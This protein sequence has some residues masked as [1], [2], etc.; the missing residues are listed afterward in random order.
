MRVGDATAENFGWPCYEGPG[1]QAGYDNLNNPVCESPL[2]RGHGPGVTAP[3]FSYHHNTPMTAGGACPDSDAGAL[4]GIT[5]YPG[6]PFPDEYDGALFFADFTRHC[7]MVMMAGA[8]GRPDPA[9]LRSSAWCSRPAAP[10]GPWP[11]DLEVGPDGVLY[12]VDVYYGCCT[13]SATPAAGPPTAADG[14]RDRH[15]GR[16]SGR[17]DRALRRLRLPRPGGRRAD[18]R[19]GPRRRRRVRRRHRR[20]RDRAPTP[21]R[22]ASP[23]VSA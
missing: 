2:P 15:P 23:P 8:D 16:R 19:L 5:F 12:Y 7:L 3:F 13:G 10:D 11:V 1:R 4:G 14:G 20:H 17:H 9:T 22:G 6:G 18:L 21:R